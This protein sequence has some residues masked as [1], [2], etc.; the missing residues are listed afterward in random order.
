MTVIQGT[1]GIQIERYPEYFP[2]NTIA[3][4]NYKST[5][6]TQKF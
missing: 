4:K 5:V 1:K 6:N 3:V 2:L